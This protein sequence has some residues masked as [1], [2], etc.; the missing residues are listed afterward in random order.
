[1][2]YTTIRH[3]V[4]KKGLGGVLELAEI[5]GGFIPGL[6]EITD[7]VGIARGILTG[8]TIDAVISAA[9]LV[10]P[11]VSGAHLKAAK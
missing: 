4:A 3:R 8:N 7:V 11:G 10:T 6:S 1:M 5:I 2:K 9:G